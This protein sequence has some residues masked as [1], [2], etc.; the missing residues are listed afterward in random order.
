[1]TQARQ[2]QPDQPDLTLDA[3]ALAEWERSVDVAITPA[4][5]QAQKDRLYRAAWQR[6]TQGDGYQPYGYD[7]PTIRASH[8]GWYATL[9]QILAM[10]TA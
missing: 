3:A 9:R 2:Q 1:M 6:M 5:T 7:W 10:P 4:L 8:P